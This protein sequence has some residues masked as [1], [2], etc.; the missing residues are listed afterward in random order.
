MQ[1]SSLRH[2]GNNLTATN[3]AVTLAE[4]PKM[5]FKSQG[6]I[7]R[8]RRLQLRYLIKVV[9]GCALAAGSSAALTTA[10]AQTDDVATYPNR[11][12]RVI[13]AVAAGG[14]MDVVARIVGQ[15]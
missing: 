3:F 8:E 1:F 13:I 7:R 5:T 9:I 15:N 12:I 11:P 10:R 4:E 14:T 2:I 6:R